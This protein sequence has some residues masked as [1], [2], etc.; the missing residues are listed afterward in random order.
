MTRSLSP[1]ATVAPALGPFSSPHA[2]PL[3][4]VLCFRT[5]AQPPTG[6]NSSRPCEGLDDELDVKSAP[7]KP[8]CLALLAMLFG[9]ES[10]EVD[11]DV[12]PSQP[13]EMKSFDLLSAMAAVGFVE[14]L[15]IRG[16][17]LSA[18]DDAFDEEN[19]GFALAGKSDFVTEI[20]I[21]PTTPVDCVFLF[22][23]AVLELEREAQV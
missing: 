12:F 2:P 23:G 17:D 22:L 16:W 10:L 1:T 19:T 13:E 6:F 4:S 5:T 7:W 14:K 21:A 20:S 8:D 3:A 9:G 15:E 18:M 11:T